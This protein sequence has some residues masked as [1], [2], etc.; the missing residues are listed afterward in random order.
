MPQISF[1][2]APVILKKQAFVERHR[3]PSDQLKVL[4]HQAIAQKESWTKK[5]LRS[6]NSNLGRNLGN[7]SLT[8]VTHSKS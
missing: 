5:S 4:V 6:P 8:F 2:M 7:I 1:L 3:L